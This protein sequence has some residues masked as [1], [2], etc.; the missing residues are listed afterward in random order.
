MSGVRWVDVAGLLVAFSPVLICSAVLLFLIL[1]DF[2]QRRPKPMPD[3]LALFNAAVAGM[4][5]HQAAQA[6]VVAAQAAAD[7]AAV[8]RQQATQ[9]LMSAVAELLGTQAPIIVL[10]A[11]LKQRLDAIDQAL[12]GQA[13]AIQTLQQQETKIM[14][15]TQDALDLCKKIDDAT[16]KQGQTLQTEADSLQKVSDGLD[17]LIAKLGT[18]G[19]VDPVIMSALQ[20]AADKAQAISDSLDAQAAWSAALA[21][22]ATDPVPAPPPVPTP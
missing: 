15:L 22:K 1:P 14:A 20:A 9:T 19:N 7:Q 21:T 18:Q 17:A 5:A 11:N 10:D 13:A 12:K 16:T 8:T 6:A 4:E 2:P 3:F